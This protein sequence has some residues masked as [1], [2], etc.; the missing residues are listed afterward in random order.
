LVTDGSRTV[1]WTIGSGGAGGYQL[2]PSNDGSRA[3]SGGT[4]SIAGTNTTISAAG[5]QGAQKSAPSSGA[6]S[7]DGGG[8]TGHNGG[9][10]RYD[11]SGKSAIYSGGGGAG[12]G[13]SGGDVSN[14][15]VPYN[16]TNPTGEST[17]GSYIGGNAGASATAH[18][19]TGGGGGSGSG[20]NGQG[21]SHSDTMYGKGGNGT[22][23]TF[24][25]FE[26]G[27][28]GNNG[29]IIFKYYGP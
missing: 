28:A 10:G 24:I 26:G 11:L 8:S 16:S 2:S 22:D 14:Y 29:A 15:T 5:G 27:A 13:G 3:S 25:L 20:S 4:T 7:L 23:P 21:S 9:G 18:G 6:R 12:S 19:L 1:T 17:A